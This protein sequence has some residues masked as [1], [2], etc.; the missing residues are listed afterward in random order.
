MQENENDKNSVQDALTF[1][2][3]IAREEIESI[4]RIHNLTLKYIG[5]VGLAFVLIGGSLS[6]IGFSNL[7]SFAVA[8]AKA[9]M[10]QEVTDQVREKL[11]KEDIEKIVRE[12]VRDYSVAELK[13]AIH[14]ELSSPPISTS[15]HDVAANEA[16]S[17]IK[18]QFAHR[19]LTEAQSRALVKAIN[20][21][22]ELGGYPVTILPASFNSEAQDY[23]EEIGTC[24]GQTKMKTVSNFFGYPEAKPVEGIGIYFDQTVPAQYA[25]SLR[26]AFIAAG[27]AAKT[28]RVDNSPPPPKNETRPLVIFVGSKFQ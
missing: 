8:T 21:R 23:S 16:R 24:I 9:Q 7:K 15:L 25:S 20:S 2:R 17:Q 26:D 1:A 4:E 5:Y 11:T 3:S 28:V 14:K 6:W 27:L 18:L 19:H 12:Q 22:P 10:R 13:N